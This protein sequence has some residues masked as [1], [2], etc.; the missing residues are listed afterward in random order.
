M[1]RVALPKRVKVLEIV[2]VP[3][4]GGSERQVV[5]LTRSLDPS[6]FEPVVESHQRP[7]AVVPQNTRQTRR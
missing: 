3:G 6:K 1:T 7:R 5:N 2:A 4:I